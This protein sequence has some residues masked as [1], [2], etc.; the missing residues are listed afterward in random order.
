MPVPFDLRLCIDD[1]TNMMPH[2]QAA[3]MRRWL[4]QNGA[5]I[6]LPDDIRVP[7]QSMG[8]FA[9]QRG[10]FGVDEPMPPYEPGRQALDDSG[11]GPEA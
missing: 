7:H 10:R 5:L 4:E 2:A 1:I 9:R 11:Q 8:N 6:V 3:F